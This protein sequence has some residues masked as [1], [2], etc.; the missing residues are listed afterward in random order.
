MLWYEI[1]DSIYRNCPWNCRG[2]DFRLSIVWQQ[3]KY[4]SDWSDDFRFD[5]FGKR[6]HCG[7]YF[8]PERVER[9]VN[10]NIVKALILS[11][12]SVVLVSL[13]LLRTADRRNASKIIASVEEYRATYGQLPDPDDQKI[14]EELGF[15]MRMEWFPD[16]QMG[17]NGNFRITILQGFDGPYWIY[18]SSTKSWREGFD[19]KIPEI[20]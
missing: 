14:M 13:F 6:N 16:Y 4:C 10:V 5:C 15:E 2:A 8:V 19:Y 17:E 1:S 18:D 11:I 9:F 7:C 20:N 3:P 12:L